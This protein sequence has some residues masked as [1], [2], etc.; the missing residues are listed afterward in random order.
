MINRV[1]K[2]DGV[3]EDF[4]F[5]KIRRAVEQAFKSCDKTP[6]EELLIKLQSNIEATFKDVDEVDIELIQ[7]AVISFLEKERGCKKVASHYKEYRETRDRA[8]NKSNKI[9]KTSRIRMLMLMK[10]LSEDVLE[11]LIELHSS[12]SLLMNICLLWQERII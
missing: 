12:N 2:R 5:M 11:R 3:R 6:S 10:C 9:L 1:I 8:R 7:D 4:T